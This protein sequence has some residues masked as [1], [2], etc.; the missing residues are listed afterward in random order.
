M[1]GFWPFRTRRPALHVITSERLPGVELPFEECKRLLAALE[2]QVTDADF[3]PIL[4]ADFLRRDLLLPSKRF[5]ELVTGLA[6]PGLAPSM[7]GC[8]CAQS[9]RQFFQ[10]LQRWSPSRKRRNHEDSYASGSVD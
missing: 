7:I 4:V 2:T 5:I 8:S 1:F 3:R 10:P 9:V 6:K